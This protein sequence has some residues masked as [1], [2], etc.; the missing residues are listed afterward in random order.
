[1]TSD[2]KKKQVSLSE[3]TEHNK[4][5]YLMKVFVVYYWCKQYFHHFCVLG[6]LIVYIECICET[7]E[8]ILLSIFPMIYRLPKGQ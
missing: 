4:L 1:M 8:E 6:E 7:S 3:R 2:S 5:E